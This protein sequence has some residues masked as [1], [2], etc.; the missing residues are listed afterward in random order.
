MIWNAI[1]P[2]RRLTKERGVMLAGFLVYGFEE[3]L[4]FLVTPLKLPLQVGR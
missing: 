2:E 1:A 3:S 4:A